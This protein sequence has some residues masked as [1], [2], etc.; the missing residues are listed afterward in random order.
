MHYNDNPSP[1]LPSPPPKKEFHPKGGLSKMG[2]HFKNSVSLQFALSLTNSFVLQILWG[3]DQCV[4]SALPQV[5][6]LHLCCC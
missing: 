6:L 3:I 4:P 2:L 1:P 5:S